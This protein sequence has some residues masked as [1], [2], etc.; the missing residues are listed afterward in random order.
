M[1]DQDFIAGVAGVACLAEPVRL[2]LYRYIS[3]QPGPVGRDEAAE[4]VGIPRHTAKFHLDKLVDEGLL[5]VEFRRL[6]GR[7][8]PGAGRPAKLYRRSTRE[9]SVTLPDR[10]YELAGDLMASAIEQ[11]AATGSDVVP[12]LHDAARDRGREVGGAVRDAVGRRAGR[13]ALLTAAADA[14]ATAGYEP[15]VADGRVT[16]ANCPFHALAQRHPELVCGMNLALL[17]EMVSPTG[18]R[19]CARLEPGE[20]Q[21]CVV[22][23]AN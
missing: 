11:A 19:L 8:G 4:A 18:G 17:E 14:L 12:A 16:L 3:A 23:S 13:A 5:E 1:A 9:I 2:A 22:V 20:G 6:T 10:E 7:V 15:Q 21:C